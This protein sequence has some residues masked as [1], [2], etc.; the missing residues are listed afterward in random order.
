MFKSKDEGSNE[1]KDGMK[2]AMKSASR[3]GG[4]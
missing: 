1:Q 2:E 3:A 4:I